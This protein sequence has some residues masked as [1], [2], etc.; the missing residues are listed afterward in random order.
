MIYVTIAL[1]ITTFLSGCRSTPRDWAHSL[2]STVKGSDTE[3]RQLAGKTFNA[4][5]TAQQRTEATVGDV[6]ESAN[7]LSNVCADASLKVS[8]SQIVGKLN[9]KTIL[10]R[11]LGPELVATELR[12][13]RRYCESVHA[14]RN[15]AFE[16]YIDHE[17]LKSAAQRVGLDLEGFIDVKAVAVQQ[18]TIPDS[19]LQAYY[20]EYKTDDDPVFEDMRAEVIEAVQEERLSQEFRLL[21]SSLRARASI[22]NYLPDVRPAPLV[23]EIP[24]HA[25]GL[26]DESSL[27]TL[28]QFADFECPYCAE[29]MHTM[30]KLQARYPKAVR[31]VYR[32]FPLDFH[33]NAY[34]AAEYAQCANA[35]AK[36]W[37]FHNLIYQHYD[38]LTPESIKEYAIQAGIDP[39]MLQQCIDEGNGRNEVEADLASASEV[40]VQATPTIFVN[41]REVRDTSMA[42]LSAAIEQA[43]NDSYSTATAERSPLPITP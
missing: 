12:M 23:I 20:E 41:G 32:H 3:N 34:I 1:A 37:P 43:L 4:A 27:V 22:E 9:D 33:P 7:I 30:Q 42:G 38:S 40:G 28:I 11:D 10:M 15:D 2:S 26:G 31:F 36:F 29:M 17:L 8:Q 25:P 5:V 39:R 18:R 35:Q 21:R 13:L 6:L 24:A 16:A 19:E 14:A